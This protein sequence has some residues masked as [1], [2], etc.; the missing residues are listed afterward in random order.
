MVARPSNGPPV[1]NGVNAT[2]E[3]SLTAAVGR[4]RSTE[5]RFGARSQRYFDLVFWP[6]LVGLAKLGSGE[7]A[8]V[9]PD[10]RSFGRG[11]A[12]EALADVVSAI[13]A[14]R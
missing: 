8:L 13:E 2:A 10:G 14:R 7:R 1:A 12:V 3:A 9:K 11:P 4:R 6:R 5:V